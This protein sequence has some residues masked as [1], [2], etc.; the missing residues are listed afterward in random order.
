MY[1]GY[2]YYWG[3]CARTMS[4]GQADQGNSGLEGPDSY[5]SIIRSRSP[6]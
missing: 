6:I 4:V 3:A 1:M 5:L 2:I